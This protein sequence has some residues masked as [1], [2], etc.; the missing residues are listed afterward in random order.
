MPF[1]LSKKSEALLENQEGYHYPLTPTIIEQVPYANV[2]IAAYN[3]LEKLDKAREKIIVNNPKLRDYQKQ[4][5]S[6]MVLFKRMGLFNQQRLGKTPTT[7]CALNAIEKDITTI[8]IAPKSTHYQWE[9]ETKK[10]YTE[11]VVRLRGT[12]TQ[13]KRAYEKGYKVYITS[14]ETASNDINYLLPLINCIIVDEAHRLRNFRGVNSK[15]SPEFTKSIAKLCYKAEYAY[16]LTG[17][18]APNYAY[19]IYPILN[20]LYPNLFKSFWYFVDYFFV[21]ETV[22]FKQQKVEQ[23][24]G[25]K[26]KKEQELQEFLNINCIQ[27]KRKDYMDWIP[28]TNII[29]IN[30]EMDKKENKWYNELNST[31]ECE[32][33]QIDCPNKLTLMNKLIQLTSTKSTKEKFI[34]DYIKDYPDEQIIITGTYSSYLRE[35]Q[36]K[37][38]NSKL[39]IGETTSKERGILEKKFNR[40]EYKVL[41]GNTDVL[42]EGIKLEQGNTIIVLNPSMVYSDNEQLYDRIVPTNKEV[43][44]IKNKQQVLLLIIPNTIDEYIQTKLDEKASSTSI[45]NDFTTLKERRAQNEQ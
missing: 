15:N 8:I 9:E 18:P 45:I 42:K 12:L 36:K 11:S 7:L 33:L 35:L 24:K 27:R 3:Y 2:R 28:K 22:Y 29:K 25:F 26:T 13:R 30:L 5:A 40:K 41:I 17:T 23:I 32:E 43:A 34:L 38:P 20:M 16:M 37:I 4:D 31:W 44:L 1:R 6:N 39:M 21:K 14:Y 10:W 19:Q